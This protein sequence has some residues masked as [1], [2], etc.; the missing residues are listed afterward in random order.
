MAE[1]WDAAGYSTLLH[2]AIESCR[3]AG[4]NWLDGGGHVRAWMADREF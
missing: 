4:L 2:G 3:H 1:N